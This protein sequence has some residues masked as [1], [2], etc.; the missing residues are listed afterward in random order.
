MG[1]GQIMAQNGMK[2][3]RAAETEKYA[4][5]TFFFNGGIEKPF[6]G[7]S[8]KLIPS[9]QVRTYDLQPEMS[10]PQVTDLVVGAIE[11]GENDLIVVNIANG[12]M[13]GHTGIWEA[14]IKAVRTVDTAVGRIVDAASKAESHLLITADHGNI[15]MMRDRGK[16]M[17]AHTTN[18]VP[19]YYTGPKQYKLR[20]G[21]RLADI[22]P[23]TLKLM[24]LE[25]PEQMTG[26]SLIK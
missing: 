23:T 8:R 14:A 9:P 10:C 26:E 15:E 1:L 16:P 5:V 25:A 2:Q 7:E 24:G 18:P 22:A 6:N 11:Q 12:D 21:G 20:N 3:F 4:H 17:T 13:V 19:F